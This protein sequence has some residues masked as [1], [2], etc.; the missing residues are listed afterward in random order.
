MAILLYV[1]IAGSLV[2]GVAA[3]GGALLAFRRISRELPPRGLRGLALFWRIGQ[4]LLLLLSLGL[5]GT[6]TVAVVRHEQWSW[7]DSVGV[8]ESIMFAL[9]SLVLV[10]VDLTHWLR[11]SSARP[12]DRP[13]MA[14]SRTTLVGAVMVATAGAL[15]YA[16][17]DGVGRLTTAEGVEGTAQAVTQLLLL[18]A[19]SGLVA[20]AGVEFAKRL[21]PLRANFN[22]TEVTRVFGRDLHE[23]RHVLLRHYAEI[24]AGPW[25]PPSRRWTES[26]SLV[27]SARW[28]YDSTIP[29]LTAQIAAA[30]RDLVLTVRQ[31]PGLPTWIMVRVLRTV[32]GDDPVVGRFPEERDDSGAE[33]DEGSTAI[34]EADLQ[35]DWRER[36]QDD[37]DRTLDELV[38]RRMDLF[39]VEALARWRSRLRLLSATFAGAVAALAAAVTTSA[40]SAVLMAA[41]LGMVV[42]GP[43]SWVARDLTRVV[44]RRAQ[45]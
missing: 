20:F 9:A 22:E 38:E 6:L 5:F 29:Q 27:L 1:Q 7:P 4:S 2:A 28:S 33:Y 30:H 36:V 14:P 45:F 10:V 41:L 11:R 37:R 12:G 8:V 39:Q 26:V 31:D 21:S 40:V 42:G 18:A 24:L 34:D 35:A 43:I 44:E 19:A 23:T 25:D 3:L 17:V 32:T 13:K 15:G 16:V